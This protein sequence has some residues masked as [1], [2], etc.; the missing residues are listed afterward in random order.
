MR[1]SKSGYLEITPVEERLRPTREQRFG[2][3]GEV[4]YSP[5]HRH[6]MHDHQAFTVT[7]KASALW[8]PRWYPWYFNVRFWVLYTDDPAAPSYDEMWRHET[9]RFWPWPSQVRGTCHMVSAPRSTRT[10]WTSK[11]YLWVGQ[12]I[13]VDEDGS[14]A[15]SGLAPSLKHWHSMRV[16]S[17]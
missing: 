8:V 13:E 12:S 14:G 9:L 6:T 10:S 11:A 15:W 5:L 3:L 16:S 1:T 4:K 2:R 7:W 17:W